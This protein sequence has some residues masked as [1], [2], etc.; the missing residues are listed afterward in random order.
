MDRVQAWDIRTSRLRIH[1]QH[2]EARRF[3]HHFERTSDMP[4]ADDDQLRRGRKGWMKT[5][6]SPP[7]SVPIASGPS[8]VSE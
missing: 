8:S 3:A 7:H 2:V 1:D 4:T 6:T 5:L